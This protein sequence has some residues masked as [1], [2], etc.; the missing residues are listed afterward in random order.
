KWTAE[1]PNLYKLL[2]T[3]KDANG[4]TVE[5]IPTNIGFR[6]VEVRGGRFLVNGKPVLIK[7]VNRHEHDEHTGKVV[8]VDSMIR[9][10]K[11]MKQFNVNAVRTSHYPNQPA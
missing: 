11:L 8:S 1:T 4:A 6:K 3:L 10:I 9:D 7:G 5:V 2:L